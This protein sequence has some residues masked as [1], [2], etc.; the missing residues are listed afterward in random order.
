MYFFALFQICRGHNTE[1]KVKP[2]VLNLPKVFYKGIT[3]DARGFSES[4]K[5]KKKKSAIQ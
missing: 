3:L 4:K 5:K 1:G 2:S